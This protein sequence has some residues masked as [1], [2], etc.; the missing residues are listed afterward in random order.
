M[1]PHL[2]QQV[3]ADYLA[4]PEVRQVD[5]AK[6]HG[7]SQSAVSK[8]VAQTRHIWK[9]TKKS[10]RVIQPNAKITQA[11]ADRIREERQLHGH[12]YIYL[13]QKYG[14]SEAAVGQIIRGKAWVKKAPRPG[15]APAGAREEVP[16]SP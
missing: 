7:I 16:T 15:A 13:A 12:K 11:I 4:D 5:L 3:Q 10:R 6:K 8:I 14:L 1:S 9:G 2:R